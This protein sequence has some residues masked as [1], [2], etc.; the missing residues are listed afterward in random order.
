[1]QI[2]WSCQ[3]FSEQRGIAIRDSVILVTFARHTVAAVGWCIQ[4]TAM[5]KLTG[6]DR[7]GHM[8]VGSARMPL[9]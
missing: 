2:I 5:K 9:V 8:G 7:D 4:G 1:M 3:A 6:L